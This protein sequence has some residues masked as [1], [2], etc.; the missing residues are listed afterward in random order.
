QIAVLAVAGFLLFSGLHAWA[1]WTEPTQDPPN[2]NVPVPVYSQGTGQA[3]DGTLNVGTPGSY[4]TGLQGNGTTTGVQGY[5]YNGNGLFGTLG[6]DG[7][8]GGRG[9]YGSAIDASDYAFYSNGG[10]GLGFTSGD[11]WF[12]LQGTGISWPRESDNGNLYGI[13]VTTAGELRLFMHG[14]GLTVR[15]QNQNTRITVSEAGN[16]GIGAGASDFFAYGTSDLDVYGGVRAY[17]FIDDNPAYYA[18]LNTGGNLGGNWTFG[19]SITSQGQPV[20]L[21]NGNG[22]PTIGTPTLQQVTDAGNTT[23]RAITVATINTGLGDFEIGQNLRT[24]DSPTFQSLTL[25]GTN[26]N[27]TQTTNP[28]VYLDSTEGVRIH[29]DSDSN[30]ASTF[31]VV[32]DN[33]TLAFSVDESGNTDIVGAS[34]YLGSGI[35]LTQSGTWLYVTDD[36]FNWSGR[37]LGAAN[38]WADS[39]LYTNAIY[40]KTGGADSIWMGDSNDT[41]QL[42]GNLNVQ[43]NVYDSGGTLTLNDDTQ[44]NGTLTVTG[45]AT[46]AGQSVCRQ[47]GTNC[48]SASSVVGWTDG[49]TN[50]Y[51]TTSTDRVGIGSSSP[52]E[53]LHVNT[54]A[55]GPGFDGIMVEGN[56]QP[57]IAIVDNGNIDT[58]TGFGIFRDQS[59]GNSNLRIARYSGGFQGST[60]D[61]TPSGNVGIGQNLTSPSAK[62]QVNASGASEALRVVSGDWSPF[63]IRNSANSADFFRIKESGRAGIGNANP[64]AD[65]DVR[66]VD[67]DQGGLATMN[68]GVQSAGGTLYFGNDTGTNR[69]RITNSSSEF[70]FYTSQT[71]GIRFYTSQDTNV[72]PVWRATIKNNGLCLGATEGTSQCKNSWAVQGGAKVYVPLGPVGGGEDAECDVA[73]GYV[74]TGLQN[75]QP[76]KLICRRMW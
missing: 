61:I 38:V 28:Q 63:I 69:R 48:P 10:L 9:V 58:G 67:N 33:N 3:I 15:D 31:E 73:N 18:D 70:G 7:G 46:V 35:R 64:I 60:I 26:L 65:L 57:G 30:D 27:F 36:A 51:L 74:M 29:L 24:T 62:L 56:Q 68:I 5:S 25:Q 71:Q 44:V 54:L 50:V 34:L 43:G 75:T 21:Q 49:G 52:T 45:N 14:A 72:D 23:T 11:I 39:Q 16:V 19:G 12:L 2:G 40:S 6:G 53:K 47:D 37:S 76:P 22:C 1:A 17:A 66:D 20:C 8:S 59:N 41:L 55:A 42:Q 32:R 4:A 13:N